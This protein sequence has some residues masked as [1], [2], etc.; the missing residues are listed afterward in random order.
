MLRAGDNIALRGKLLEAQG[1]QNQGE[2]GKRK[3]LELQEIYKMFY[4]SG[5]E[6]VKIISQGNLRFTLSEN[7]FSLQEFALENIGRFYDHDESSYLK[8]LV[9]GEKGDISSEMKKAFIDAGVMHLIAVSRLNAAYIIISL[10]VVLSLFR[11]NLK[12]RSV[13]TIIVLV[14]YCVF[15]GSTPSIL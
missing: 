15:A 11:L 14:F 5:Y 10:T 8:G 1:R 6:N 13:I 3:Y 2:F 12:Y 9:T 4:V 7:N